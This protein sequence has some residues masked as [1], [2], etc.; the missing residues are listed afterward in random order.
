[1]D[2][3][4]THNFVDA[5]LVSKRGL[6]TEEFERFTVAVA[7]GYTMTCLDGVPDLE[8]KLGNYTVT[9]TF[10]VVDLSD[11]NVVLGVQWLYSLGEIGFNY[12]TL[13]MSF[14]DTN[15]SR[16]VWR[17][18]ST[19]APRTVSTKRMERIFRHGDVAYVAE[20]LITTRRDS[21]G[22]QHYHLEIR[23]LL[24]QYEPVFGPIPSGRPPDN[25]FEHT[26][27]LEAG[28]TSM[29]IAPY[30]HPK[31][32]KDEIEKEIK[33]L[34]EMVHI[35]PNTSLFASSVVLV[36]NKDGTLRMCIDYRELNK[37]TIKNRYPLPRIDEL[38]DELHGAVFFTNIDLCSGYHQINILRR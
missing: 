36:L 7:D 11:A 9:N 22:R 4:A 27:E 28:M 23:E 37:K 17:G 24:S 38:M 34:L 15:G 25:G 20:S 21:N 12:Q 16:V 1:V 8:V 32:F 29:I 13:K 26:T 31:R 14:K 3:G 10:Y 6:Q 18:M 35:R 2:G 30:R 19:G 33:Y 5:C